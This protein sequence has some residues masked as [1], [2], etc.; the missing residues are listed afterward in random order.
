[1]ATTNNFN[2]GFFNTSSS[3]SASSSVLL[4]VASSPLR[5]CRWASQPNARVMAMPPACVEYAR[6]R[7]EESSSLVKATSVPSSWMRWTR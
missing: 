4:T 2:V 5:T 1:M 7:V 6:V 3:D